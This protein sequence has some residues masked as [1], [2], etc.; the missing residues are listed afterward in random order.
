[1][2]QCLWLASFVML[3]DLLPF[4]TPLL[5]SW[6]YTQP[7]LAEIFLLGLLCFLC[8]CCCGGLLVGLLVSVR[9]RAIVTRLLVL[10]LEEPAQGPARGP[11]DR[12]LQYRSE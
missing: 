5:G 7:R 6:C 12:L 1:M 2:S 4:V 9:C 8:G 3:K 10:A 11:R